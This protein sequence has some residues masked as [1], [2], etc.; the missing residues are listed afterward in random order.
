VEGFKGATLHCDLDGNG[1]IDTSLS[2]TGL[3]Q[4]QLATPSYG[5]VDGK[6]YIF[7]S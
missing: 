1:L 4:A 5:L 3:S 2:F 7:F 6:D